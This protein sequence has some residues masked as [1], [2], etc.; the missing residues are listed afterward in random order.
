[1]WF[2]EMFGL[3]APILG[4]RDL[5]FTTQDL[6]I[7]I[8]RYEPGEEHPENYNSLID[9]NKT[10]RNLIEYK[11]VV[12]TIP[13]GNLVRRT[14]VS[15]PADVLY[16]YSATS[17]KPDSDLFFRHGSFFNPTG[18]PNVAHLKQESNVALAAQDGIKTITY[19]F[20]YVDGS[21]TFIPVDPNSLAP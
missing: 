3:G 15:R 5:A 14:T 20:T 9:P 6:D 16:W 17:H 8:I 12:G 1:T 18:L 7:G 21:T 10:L 19:G 13:G 11:T 2:G 4:E